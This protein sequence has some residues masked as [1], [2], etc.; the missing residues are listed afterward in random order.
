MRLALRVARLA[1]LGPSPGAPTNARL[2]GLGDWGWHWKNLARQRRLP[3]DVPITLWTRRTR[4]K[5]EAA[6]G[7]T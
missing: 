5:G 7:L 6:D 3:A 1:A 2:R 4:G